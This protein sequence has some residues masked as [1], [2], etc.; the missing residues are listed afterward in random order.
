MDLEVERP[1]VQL[2]PDEEVELRARLLLDE[3]RSARTLVRSPNGP[4]WAKLVRTFSV[5]RGEC[6]AD[7]FG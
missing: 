4:T 3:T 2:G 6:M 5:D 7:V 1:Y